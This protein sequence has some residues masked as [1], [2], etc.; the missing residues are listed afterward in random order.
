V[1]PEKRPTPYWDAFLAAVWPDEDMRA[2]ALRVLAVAVTGYADKALPIMLGETDRGKTS[3]IDLM[4]SVLGSYAHT[5][6][7]RLLSP[8]DKSHASIVYA[9]KGRRLSFIDEAPRAGTLAQ[10]RLKQITGGADL[11][12]N[13][14]AENPV[15]F[16]PTHTLVLTANPE[17]EPNLADAAIRRRV[18]LI[19]CDGDPAAVIAARAA[20]GNLNGA[21]WRGEAPGVLAAMMAEAAA[22]LADPRSADSARAPEAGQA[23]ALEIQQSQDP[24]LLWVEDE[25]E[26]WEQGTRAHELYMAFTDSCKRRNIYQGSIPS[27]T[28]WGRRLK[29]LGYE[30]IERMDGRYRPLRIRPPH[31]FVPTSAEFMGASGGSA[32]PDGGLMEGSWR[33]KPPISQTLH[34]GDSAAQTLQQPSITPPSMEGMEGQSGI[35]NTRAP[36]HAHTHGHRNQPSNPPDPPLPVA[37]APEP[38]PPAEDPAEPSQP[39]TKKRERKAKAEPKPRE[40]KPPKPAPLRPDPAL[41]GPVYPLPVLTARNPADPG[42]PPL[43]LPCSID[44]AVAAVTPYLG[45]LSVDVEHSGYPV[46]HADYRLRL[47]QL[48]GEHIAAVFDPDDP[49]QQDAI[50]DLV[51][52]AGLLHAH[53][54]CADLVPLAWAGLGDRDAM[55]SR[56]EDSVLIAKLGDPGLAGS[57][58][59]ELKRLALGLL[60]GYSAS[61]PADEARSALFKSGRWL[62]NLKPDTPVAKSGWANVKPGCETFARYAGSDVLDL[63]AVLR[64]LPR[65]DEGVLARERQFQ[66]V[67]S[68]VAHDGFR[69][70]HP[71]IRLKTAEY[72]QAR[73]A[74]QRRVAEL[75]GG[76]I[77]NPSSS[78]EVPAALAAMGVPLGLTKDGNPSA[79]KDVLEPLAKAKG[80]EHAELCSQ[81]LEYRHDVTTLGLLLN[82]LNELCVRGDGRMRPVVYTINADTG[83]TSC[84]RPNGQQFSRQGGIRACVI[85]DDEPVPMA[86][87]AADFSGVEIRVGSALA[88]DRALL[89]AE[90]STRCLACGNDPCAPWCGLAQNGLHWMAA[91][92]AFGE[93]AVKEDRYNSKRIIFSKMFG[94][95]PDTGAKQVGVPVAAGRAVHRAFEQI[96]PGYAA[97]DQ[98][99]R[100]YAKAGNRAWQAYSG[101]VIWL[102]RGRFHAA[103]NY[104]I[105]GTARELLVDGVLRWKQTR[106]GHYP[107]LPIHDEILTWVPLAEAE[108]ALATLM[109]CMRNQRFYETYGVP[110]EAKGEGPFHAWPDSS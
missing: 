69:L 59:S 93:G 88:G 16:S 47:V 4:M 23:A 82:P 58:E 90:L 61:K 41:E 68:R 39:V 101:R 63:A 110:I 67:C 12:G 86:G 6:D 106:W 70:D 54:A 65:P 108:E 64:V 17:H 7:A 78:K 5:A 8:A 43:V 11:T 1:T 22:W 87:I 77:A 32:R 99:M 49:A 84:V 10:E 60:G 57:E 19:P 35:L 73:D 9:L 38:G 81:I 80:Y 97:W 103:G 42:A 51:A 37:P 92:M 109:D 98:E 75:T 71:H 48:G 27:E 15:T 107:L 36:A 79:A 33:V 46:G 53:S 40:P 100:A 62:T 96:A 13:R 25:C 72:E 45:D 29:E 3:V 21:R 89:D 83:R 74:A 24:V 18:R 52:R 30:K 34:N 50:R 94:G 85:A 95:G 104:C 76:A 2:W 14:M 44:E 105:Q 20:I 56:M 66:A 91:R 28:A 102:P 31:S 26:P 55:W